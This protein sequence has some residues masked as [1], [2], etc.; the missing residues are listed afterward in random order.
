MSQY[1]IVILVS[2]VL[3]VI[4][5][6]IASKITF[7]YHSD[8]EGIFVLKG[9]N[10]AWLEI[11]DD[12]FPEQSNRLLWGKPLG[13]IKYSESSGACGPSNKP[14]ISFEWNE[15]SGRGFIKSLYPDGRK[16]IFNLGRF[17]D[18]DGRPVSGLFMGG[19]LPPSDPDYKQ[20]DRNETGMAYFDGS[21]YFHIW[22]N[23]NEGI[24]DATNTPIYPSQWQFVSSKVVESSPNDVT[25]VSRH[26]VLINNV[27]VNVERFLFYQNGDAFVTLV[28]NFINVGQAPTFFAYLYGD[29]PW[30]GDYGSSSGNVGWLKDRVALTEMEIDTSRYTYAGMFDHG[31]PLAGEHHE[32]HTQKANFIEWQPESR[33]DTAYFAN[34]FG[35]YAP[36][37]KKVPLNSKDKRIIALRWGPRTLNP[38]D[39]FSFTITVGMADNDPKTG[40]PV[41]PD[42][43]L[44]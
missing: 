38:G 32:F 42:T 16:L 10:G 24:L 14:C 2:L 6:L 4:C 37:E 28:T 41:K 35:W 27:P 9:Q 34:Q 15:K 13:L 36:A 33:P 5:A 18:S 17:L 7:S 12:L 30:I 43:H 19:G 23:A 31:N 20:F 22:C 11:S 1:R 40:L 21:R 26:R 29:E 39:S 25:I 8:H 44:F 3:L